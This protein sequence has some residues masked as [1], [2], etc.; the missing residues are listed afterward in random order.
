[1]VVVVCQ[2]FQGL[3]GKERHAEKEKE[4]EEHVRVY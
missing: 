1:M 3:E 2:K 4:K